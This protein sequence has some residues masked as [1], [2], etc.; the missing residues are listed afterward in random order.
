MKE[1]IKNRINALCAEMKTA[2][3]AAAIIPQADP[4]MSEYLSDHWKV[5]KYLSGFTGSAGN[6]VIT[7]DQVLLWTDSRYF[8]Q[9]AAQLEGTGIMLMKDGLPDTPSQARWL[10]DNLKAGDVVGVDGMLLSIASKNDL[11]MQLNACGIALNSNFDAVDKVWPNRPPLPKGKVFIQPMEYA[12]IKASDK[13]DAILKDTL[14]QRADA[15]FISALDEI[16]WTLNLRCDDV[17][18]NPVATAYLYLSDSAKTLFIDP[19]KLDDK[20]KDYLASE[21]VGTAPYD[22]AA[23]AISSLGIDRHILL[24]VARTSAGIYDA[25]G[26]KAVKGEST[27]SMAKACK[28]A[29]EIEGELAALRRD[30]AA[31]VKSLREIERRLAE[32][33]RTTEWDVA[34]ILRHFRSQSDKFFDESFGTIAG[35]ADH[36]A[37]VHYEP[38]ETSAYELKPKGILLIDSGAQYFDGTTDITRTIALG[39]T[40]ETERRDF[41]LVTKGHIALASAVFPMGTCGTQLDILARQYMWKEGVNY[42]HGTGHGVGSFLNVH[43]GPHQFR[44]NHMPA[45]I[46]LG[47]VT[48]NEP[49]IY[50][51]GSHGVRLENLMLTVPAMET[52]FGKYFRFDT[53]TLCPIDTRLL[54]LD[55]MTNQEIEWINTYHARVAEEIAPLLEGDDLSWLK[56]RTAPI[57]LHK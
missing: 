33:V 9:A 10:C 31:M 14:R 55:I 38:S 56:E 4:H 8:L 54:E 24:D 20:T 29:V 1:E 39:E 57:P 3:I 15:V 16:A 46:S 52:E 40:T 26:P 50:R 42:L 6:L 21:G 27:V 34:L 19:D 41:T 43:E 12:G 35:Y 36:G 32:G 22:R 47:M 37:V 45:P 49:G 53:I 23:S 28:N 25:A 18:Y 51:A 2:G 11:E 17:R 30:G 13:I 44:M 48:S 7:H 5:R